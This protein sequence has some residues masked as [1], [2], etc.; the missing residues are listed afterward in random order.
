MNAD[1]IQSENKNLLYVTIRQM[2]QI[3]IEKET[4]L[5]SITDGFFMMD[6]NAILTFINKEGERKLKVSRSEVIGKSLWSVLPMGE[7][8]LTFQE[9]RRA[10]KENIAVHFE[11][12]CDPLNIVYEASAYPSELGLSV[13][14]KDITENKH[15]L[16]LEQLE[17]EVL[18]MNALPNSTLGDIIRYYLVGMEKIHTGMS[19]S[20]LRLEGKR[21]YLW[22]A[23]SLPKE[24]TNSYEALK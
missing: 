22:E 3:D 23:P 9:F 19:C 14:F 17:R 18:E 10:I 4:V 8:S 13:Y 15:L 1:T 12:T 6:K 24:F 16:A 7:D 20:I 5:E 11:D 2:K 21:L